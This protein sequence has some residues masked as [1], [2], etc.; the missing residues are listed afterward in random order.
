VALVEEWVEEWVEEALE[1]GAEEALEEGL[2]ESVEEE[3]E[4]SVEEVSILSWILPSGLRELS[5]FSEVIV[6]LGLF[7]V[8]RASTLGEF[9]LFLYTVN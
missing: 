3:V 1:E 6:H 7:R 4:E 9:G 5:F 8:T 2:E